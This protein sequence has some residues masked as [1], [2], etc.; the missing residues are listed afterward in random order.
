VSRRTPTF[1]LALAIVVALVIAGYTMP[2]PYVTLVPGPVYNTLGKAPHS[3]RPLIKVTGH[4]SYSASGQL[5]LVTVAVTNP[6][7]SP[8]LFG[9]ITAW[10]D[11]HKAIVPAPVIYPPS[12]SP[13]QVTQQQSQEMQ[14]SQD[15][16]IVAAL[17]HLGV[18]VH[19]AVAVGTIS[20]HTPAE[21][22]LKKGDVI[23]AVDGEHVSNANKLRKLISRRRPG[24]SVTLK[25]RRNGNERT[26]T[27]DTVAASK[28]SQRAIVGFVPTLRPQFPFAISFGL[29]GVGGPSAGLMYTLGIIA[30]L[31]RGNLTGGK[32]VAGTGTITA[33]G[34]VGQI[35]GIEQKV[36]AARRH[37]A[38]IFLT[39]AANCAAARRTAPQGLRL[40]KV[41]TLHDALSALHH[42][43]AGKGSA[44]RS[45]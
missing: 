35:G 39:P 24:Q 20:A 16:A 15:H 7:S 30:K 5:A 1:L 31:T 13:G 28:H 17:R 38:T 41:K 37:G 18:P 32:V 25:I 43:A 42:F 33:A 10:L 23:L 26:V 36:V 19:N 3:D 34:K 2:V 12:E 6:D 45:C 8:T 22:K 9:A 14:S 11:P 21:K 40:A 29:R 44:V 4:K 27:I